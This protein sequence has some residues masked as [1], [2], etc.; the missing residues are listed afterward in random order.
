VSSRTL[1]FAGLVPVATGAKRMSTEQLPPA[2]TETPT[3]P[4]DATM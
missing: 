2:G 1:T 4:F 3:Q